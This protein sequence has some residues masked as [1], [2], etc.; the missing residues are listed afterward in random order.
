VGPTFETFVPRAEVDPVY[1]N[2]PYYVYPDGPIAVETFCVIGTAM[3]EAGAI[4]I[5]RVTLSRRERLVMVEPRDAGMVLITLRALRELIEAKMKGLPVKLKEIATPAL[6]LMA[7]L[8]CSLA[9]ESGAA[10]KPKRKPA[11]D[12]RQTNLLLPVPG[13]KGE[14]NTNPGADNGRGAARRKA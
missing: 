2:T 12:R 9:Q 11:A 14:G 1:F 3:V 10:A 5:G 7:A 13:K 8:K 6:D 4:G